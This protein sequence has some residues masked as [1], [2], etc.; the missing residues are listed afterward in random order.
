MLKGD[1]RYLIAT[2]KAHQNHDIFW[3]EPEYRLFQIARFR[4]IWIWSNNQAFF[5]LSTTFNAD[6]I[7][8]LTVNI[9]AKRK[10]IVNRDGRELCRRLLLQHSW[11]NIK[12]CINTG[13]LVELWYIFEVYPVPILYLGSASFFLL[14]NLQYPHGYH[15][16]I[17]ST[18][19]VRSEGLR[20]R[21]NP[22]LN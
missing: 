8:N 17:T 7:I 11:Q 9:S 5:I 21:A 1:S 12:G 14:L 3:V 22:C 16:G 6:L 10:Q 13:V 18:A 4:Y 15:Q 19:F 2:A 20:K